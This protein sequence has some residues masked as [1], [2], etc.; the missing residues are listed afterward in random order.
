MIL[1]LQNFVEK[2]SFCFSFFN[3]SNSFSMFNINVK[4][5]SL[6]PKIDRFKKFF[7]Q[8]SEDHFKCQSK[9]VRFCRQNFA[10]YCINMKRLYL[11]KMCYF[12][13]INGTLRN[14]NNFLNNNIYSYLETSGGQSSNLYLKVVHF[15]NTNVN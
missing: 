2:N 7:I 6:Y 15:P 5:T 14:V 13:L 12:L 8:T 3:C 4:S 11:L 9:M 10:I 1:K